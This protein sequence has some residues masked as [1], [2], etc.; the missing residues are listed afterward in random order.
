VITERLQALSAVGLLPESLADRVA[1][2]LAREL[3]SDS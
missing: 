2:Q 1:D 3:V